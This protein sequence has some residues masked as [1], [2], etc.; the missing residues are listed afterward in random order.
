M[1]VLPTDRASGDVIESADIDAIATQVNT[2]TT[3]IATLDSGKLE[4]D[5]SNLT[6]DAIA[7]LITALGLSRIIIQTPGIDTLGLFIQTDD[8]DDTTADS[9]DAALWAQPDS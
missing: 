7:A 8:P 6:S 9:T 5:G 2:N 4:L 1:A 3:D